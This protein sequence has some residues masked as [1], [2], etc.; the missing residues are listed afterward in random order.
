MSAEEPKD[1]ARLREAFASL[2]DEDASGAVDTQ[3]IFGALHGDMTPEERQSV[4]E[5]L[6]TNSAAAEAWR[7]AAPPA[8]IPAA[9]R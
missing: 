9:R 5:Q 6:L 2:A 7:L 8:S 4:V 1:V 3:H